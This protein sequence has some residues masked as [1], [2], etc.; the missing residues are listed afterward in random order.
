MHFDGG[1]QYSSNWKLPTVAFSLLCSDWR[2]FKVI[3][4]LLSM[5]FSPF[6]LS[7]NIFF[8]ASCFI[9]I[10]DNFKAWQVFSHILAPL[11]LLQ[12]KVYV[13]LLFREEE[14]LKIVLSF[15]HSFCKFRSMQ[16][17]SNLDLILAKLWPIFGSIFG[18]FSWLFHSVSDSFLKNLFSFFFAFFHSLQYH[19]D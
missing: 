7:K 10:L 16:F 8:F 5:S 15:L 1:N 3:L 11:G 14:K 17:C 18:T 12:K 19:L 4:P 13:V 6:F 2:N 9:C